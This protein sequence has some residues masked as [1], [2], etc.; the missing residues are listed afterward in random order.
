MR[1]GCSAE[2]DPSYLREIINASEGIWYEQSNES[3]YISFSILNLLTLAKYFGISW[4]ISMVTI[5]E[6][7]EYTKSKPLLA[8][9][10]IKKLGTRTHK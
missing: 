9:S 7:S 3:L 4:I 2:G 1:Q 5:M 6:N 8:H 10:T